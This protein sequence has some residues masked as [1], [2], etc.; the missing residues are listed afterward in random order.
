MA[1]EVHPGGQY[2]ITRLGGGEIH[3]WGQYRMARRRGLGDWGQ[4][5]TKSIRAVGLV[6]ASY[7]GFGGV[8]SADDAAVF[9]DSPFGGDT[10]GGGGGGF[11]PLS[12]FGVGGGSRAR[13]RLTT[14]QRSMI[15]GNAAGNRF[16]GIIQDF[17]TPW[18]AA[19][20]LR[21]VQDLGSHGAFQVVATL[22]GQRLFAG[23]Y[24]DAPSPGWLTAWDSVSTSD[25]F[26]KNTQTYMDL[27]QSIAIQTGQT[28][29]TNRN[30][31]LTDYTRGALIKIAQMG[32]NR[33]AGSRPMEATTYFGQ[34]TG[35]SLQPAGIFGLPPTMMPLLAYG[36][37]A[38]GAYKLLLGGSR[39]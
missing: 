6:A 13:L 35:Q 19:K 5:I 38:F 3:P 20:F 15:A 36:L 12:L 37:I 24:D 33:L 18:E 14:P 29:A 16:I 22:N 10:G 21:N 11:S 31:G 1:R 4:D 34:D 28:G 7:Y 17:Q 39:R 27:A 25:G 2:A 9:G 8:A 23:D 32:V 30:T 26:I